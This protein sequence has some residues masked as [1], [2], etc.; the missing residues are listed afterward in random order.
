MEK[1][2]KDQIYLA[3]TVIL[4][5][6]LICKNCNFQNREPILFGCS[7]WLIQIVKIQKNKFRECKENMKN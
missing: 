5:Y 7:S 1:D 3:S 6:I 4:I 2:S